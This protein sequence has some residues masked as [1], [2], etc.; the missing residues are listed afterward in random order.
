MVV[1]GSLAEREVVVLPSEARK[2]V[3]DV[4]I[5]GTMCG[6]EVGPAAHRLSILI[7][8][9]AHLGLKRESFRSSSNP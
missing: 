4:E 7:S 6:A 2:T 5:A 3:E 8:E 1:T 9:W